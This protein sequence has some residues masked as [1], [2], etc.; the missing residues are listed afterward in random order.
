M[1]ATFFFD[2]MMRILGR[3]KLSMMIVEGHRRMESAEGGG[4]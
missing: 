2:E 4:P 3:D 1:D